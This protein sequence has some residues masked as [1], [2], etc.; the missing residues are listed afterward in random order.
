MLSIDIKVLRGLYL[1]LCKVEHNHSGN[2]SDKAI[3]LM[4]KAHKEILSIGHK[5]NWDCRGEDL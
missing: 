5:M 2:V 4:D 1:I 3:P